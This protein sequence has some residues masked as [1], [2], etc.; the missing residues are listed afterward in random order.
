MKTLILNAIELKKAVEAAGGYS[1]VGFKAGLDTPN[2][3]K[4]C[5]GVQQNVNL[6]T[7][8]R[9]AYGTGMAFTD[10]L[11]CVETPD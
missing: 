10:L 5:N 6:N 1:A 4:Y 9:L 2:L 8:S 3:R 7:L 11:E